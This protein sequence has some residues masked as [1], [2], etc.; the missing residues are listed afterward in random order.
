ML[1]ARGTQVWPNASVSAVGEG[2]I[3][4]HGELGIDLTIDCDTVID[5]SDMLQ[6]VSLQEELKDFEVV[7]V[8]DCNQPYNIAEAIA[9]GNLAARKI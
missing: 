8:G 1:Y 3:T 4:I 2:T 9:A 6:N 5:A 7:A